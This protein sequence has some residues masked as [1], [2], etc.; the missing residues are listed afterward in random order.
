MPAA[1]W[2]IEPGLAFAT[3]TNGLPG[4]SSL[5][6]PPSSGAASVLSDDVVLALRGDTVHLGRLLAAAGVYAIVVVTA[7]APALSGQQPIS[8]PPPPGLLV[9]LS[10]QVD[11]YAESEVGGVDLFINTASHGIVA[12]RRQPLSETASPGSFWGAR[13]WRP[14]LD[15]ATGTGTTRGGTLLG[16]LSPAGDFTVTVD[17][18]VATRSPAFG[19][20][21]SWRVGPGTATLSLA[22]PPFNA[23]LAALVLVMWLAV[24]VAAVGVDRLER[25]AAWVRRRPRAPTGDH[26]LE[27]STDDEPTDV[28]AA[29]FGA[30]TASLEGAS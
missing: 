1:S 19:W 18:K 8:T 9:A 20:A 15:P 24:L 23:I 5:F 3:S 6:V 7:T 11:L 28:E 22:A 12:I 29:G 27:G 25:F 26:R 4:G 30:G 17:G 2:P 10:H 21:S 16:T 14:V 13:Y